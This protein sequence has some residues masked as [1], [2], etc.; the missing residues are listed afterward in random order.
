LTDDKQVT[1]R[2]SQE[3]AILIIKPVSPV[4]T[5]GKA[6]TGEVDAMVSNGIEW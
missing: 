3:A 1:E 4:A 6:I 2:V 5:W